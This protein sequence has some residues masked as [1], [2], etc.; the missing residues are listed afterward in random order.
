MP[1]L[2]ADGLVMAGY[3]RRL[4]LPRDIGQMGFYKPLGLIR[5]LQPCASLQTCLG[6]SSVNLLAGEF[7]F[8]EDLCSTVLYKIEPFPVVTLQSRGPYGTENDIQCQPWDWISGNSREGRSRRRWIVH[9]RHPPAGR[10][11]CPL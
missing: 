4:L 11:P 9:L 7:E 6:V 1:T 3:P 8:N 10:M 2:F 5:Q